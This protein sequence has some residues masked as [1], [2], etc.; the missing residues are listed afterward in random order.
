VCSVHYLGLFQYAE[1][2]V[3]IYINNLNSYLGS[4]QMQKLVEI[5]NY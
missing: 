1:S 2:K 5:V 3:S 4:A